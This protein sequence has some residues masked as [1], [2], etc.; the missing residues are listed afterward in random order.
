VAVVPAFEAESYIGQNVATILQLQL[1]TGLRST[2]TSATISAADLPLPSQ[3]FAEADRVAHVNNAQIVVWGRA[4]HLGHGVV[5]QPNASIPRFED[6]RSE[7][8]EEWTVTVTKH[9]RIYSITADLPRRRYVFSPIVLKGSVVDTYGKPDAMKLY[10]AR[11]G[12]EIGVL[13]RSFTL[14]EAH[15]DYAK[16]ASQKGVTGYVNLPELSDSRTE[17][18]EFV[19]GLLRLFRGDF[20]RAATDFSSLAADARCST[21]VRVDSLLLLASLKARNNQ[22]GGEEIDRAKSLNPHLQSVAI[23][24]TMVAFSASA[25]ARTEEQKNRARGARN[26]A[27]ERY[28]ALCGRDDAWLAKATAFADVFNSL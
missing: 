2:S 22:G 9:N 10:D 5:V 16:V 14:L 12:R 20:E 6:F 25:S 11:G 27:I 28:R 7:R 13:G 24:E 1:F 3:S 21:T 23:Y 17:V 8:P 26:I 18:T 4:W 15:P 19:G